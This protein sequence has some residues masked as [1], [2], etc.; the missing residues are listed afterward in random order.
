MAAEYFA[1]VFTA[2]DVAI[3]SGKSVLIHCMAGAHRAGTVGMAVL[4]HLA[5]AVPPHYHKY[6][7][8]DGTLAAA[9]KRRLATVVLLMSA[10]FQSLVGKCNFIFAVS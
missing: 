10:L 7:S 8:Y 2:V 4:M 5:T 9:M 3:G 1:P 6:A